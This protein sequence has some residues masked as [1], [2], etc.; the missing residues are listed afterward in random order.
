A[1]EGKRV[2]DFSATSFGCCKTENRSQSFAS[3][4]K[5]IAHRSVKRRW[6]RFRLRLITIQRAVDLLLAR[7]EIRFQIHGR[8]AG[9]RALILD[10]KI[11]H[12]I[13]ST[14]NIT[15]D[16]RLPRLWRLALSA[17]R[18]TRQGAKWRRSIFER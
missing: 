4:E 11:E 18:G 2:A 17:W 6:F 10:T 9:I 16:F 1:G 15:T 5:A 13:S 14:E 3:G 12:L 7:A 8:R